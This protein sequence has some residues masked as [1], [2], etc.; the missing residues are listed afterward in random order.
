MIAYL[1]GNILR[2]EQTNCIVCVEDIGYRVY[3][4][5]A[6]LFKKNIGD[7]AEFFIF[8]VVREQAQDLYGFLTQKEL[9]LF[10]HLTSVSGIGPKTALN[11]LNCASPEDIARAIIR[12]DASLLKQIQGIGSKTAERIVIELKSKAQG[13]SVWISSTDG[14]RDMQGTSDS[15]LMDALMGLGYSNMEARQAVH[16]LPKDIEQDIESRLKAALK[17]LGRK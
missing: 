9:E 4:S 11:I 10:E 16:S 3:C 5:E 14:E 8:H 17:G 2:I 13:F 7:T 12:G 6:T 15:E 1:R